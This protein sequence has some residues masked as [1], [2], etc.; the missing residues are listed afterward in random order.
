MNILR[1]YFCFLGGG[2]H[3]PSGPLYL[4]AAGKYRRARGTYCCPPPGGF[5]IT[6]VIAHTADTIGL[7]LILFKAFLSARMQTKH[8]SQ[9]VKLLL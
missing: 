6:T 9:N 8:I 4:F 1:I 7:V 5:D 3:R 2:V